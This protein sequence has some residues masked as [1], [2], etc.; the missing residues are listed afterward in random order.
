MPEPNWTR[1]A[2]CRLGFSL[3][4]TFGLKF[5][6]PFPP[7][8]G[9]RGPT[10]PSLML[11]EHPPGPVKPSRRPLLAWLPLKS[12]HF[13]TE[14]SQFP[15]LG[16][17]WYGRMKVGL[18]V[19]MTTSYSSTSARRQSKKP[20]TACL[21]AASGRKPAGGGYRR[22]GRGEGGGGPLPC[23][24]GEAWELRSR[25]SLGSAPHVLDGDRKPL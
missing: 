23:F 9:C 6:A 16:C 18:T 15:G 25:E 8:A 24:L 12:S 22:R 19:L 17:T 11:Q 21:E 14:A 20:S 4:G 2:G 10:T 3:P 7:L 1:S 5:G 13:Q